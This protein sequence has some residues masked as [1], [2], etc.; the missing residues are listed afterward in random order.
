MV[1]SHDLDATAA[2]PVEKAASY[3]VK[4][5]RLLHDDRAL[6][7]AFSSRE[8]PPTDPS[9]TL[10]RRHYPKPATTDSAPSEARQVIGMTP[11]GTDAKEPHP[12]LNA[13]RHRAVVVSPDRPASSS[14]QR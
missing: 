9:V 14:V 5:M 11:V 13:R 10:R 2:A 12:N 4:H 8:R 3:L 6:Y 7:W 1:K